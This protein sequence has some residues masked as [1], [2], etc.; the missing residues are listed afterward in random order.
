MNKILYIGAGEDITLLSTFPQ[1]KFVYIDSNP[2][3]SYG[4]PYYYK[5]L[6]SPGFKQRIISKLRENGIPQTSHT[7]VFTEEFKEISVPDL[8]SNMV[9]F[10]RLKYYFSTSLPHEDY[11]IF[12]EKIIPSIYDIHDN[13]LTDVPDLPDTLFVCGHYPHEDALEMLKKP[14]HFIGSYPTF[15]PKDIEELEEDIYNR[16]SFMKHI[17]KDLINFEK[18]N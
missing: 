5:P 3:N 7:V 11:R 8:E 2:R 16:E 17:E 15:F 6:Y 18:Q 10:G 14:F 4:Y 1:S 12:K 9:D 13:N